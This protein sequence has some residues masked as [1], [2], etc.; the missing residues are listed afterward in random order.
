MS[1]QH[2]AEHRWYGFHWFRREWWRYLFSGK[3]SLRRIVCRIQGHP[4]PVRWF[5]LYRFEP[6]MRCKNC[7]E[8]LG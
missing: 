8:D 6:D 7:D 2:T 5:T 4:Y 1:G 3:P